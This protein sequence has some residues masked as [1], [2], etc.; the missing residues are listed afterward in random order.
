VFLFCLNSAYGTTQ[1]EISPAAFQSEYAKAAVK[2]ESAASNVKC[3]TI[4]EIKAIGPYKGRVCRR[5]VVSNPTSR[6][7]VDSYET[8]SGPLAGKAFV[9]C[10][11]RDYLF[12]LERSSPDSPYKLVH[13]TMDPAELDDEGLIFTRFSTSRA[14]LDVG[15]I[16]VTRLI[17]HPSFSLKSISRSKSENSEISE[18][19]VEMVFEASDPSHGIT[20]G[21]V[22]FCPELDWSLLDYEVGV[23]GERGNPKGVARGV[24]K[25]TKLWGKV[26][27]KR[28]PNGLVFPVEA[29]YRFRYPV[30]PHGP[31]PLKQF[32][33]T[34]AEF[35]AIPDSQFKPSAF[36]ITDSVLQP[37][38]SRSIRP[39]YWYIG[40]SILCFTLAVVLRKLSK[41][42]RT[43]RANIV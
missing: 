31:E 16:P 9:Y 8:G 39:L 34:D 26:H 35:E 20:G 13:F 42:W 11:T 2:L 43:R 24:P 33:V 25:G 15:W 1:T 4:F 7:S 14:A 38:G 32:R 40:G 37:R 27:C 19:R 22:A 29:E 23:S 36:G 18:S 30:E 21:R 17:S 3:T 5:D 6:I 10:F 41:Y 12:R 28:W